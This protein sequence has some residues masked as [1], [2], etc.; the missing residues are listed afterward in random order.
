MRR[1]KYWTSGYNPGSIGG[2]FASSRKISLVMAFLLIFSGFWSGWRVETARAD[3]ADSILYVKMEGDDANGGTGWDDAF[4]TLQKAL[5][6]A[7]TSSGQTYQIWIAKGTYIPTHTFPASSVCVERRPDPP[8]PPES[9]LCLRY[10]MQ[11]D[12]RTAHFAMKNDVAIYGGFAG[13]EDPATFSLADRDFANNETILSGDLGNHLAAYHVFYHP[14]LALD[15][16]AVLD[17]VTISGGRGVEHQGYGGGMYNDRSSPAL[18]HVTFSGNYAQ[19]AGGAMANQS[20]NPTLTHV[21]ISGNEARRGGGMYNAGGSSPILTHVTISDNKAFINEGGG[22]SNNSGSS[23]VLTHV[24]ISGNEA[25]IGGG[26]YNSDSSPTL[27]N[28]I[29]SG[30]KARDISPGG[31]VGG[32]IYTRNGSLTLT[33]VTIS[34]NWAAFEAGGMYNDESATTIRNSIIWGNSTTDEYNPSIVISPWWS[35]F[36]VISHSL[37]EYSN[38][39][40][41]NWNASVGSD[42]GNNIDADP[43][44]VDYQL[45][46]IDSTSSGDYRLRKDSPAIN[47]GNSIDIPNG[48]ITDL[49]GNIRVAGAS[50][51]MGA[52]EYERVLPVPRNLIGTAGDRQVTLSWDVVNF[53]DSYEVYKYEGATGPV[54]TDDWELVARDINVTTYEVTEL[55]NGTGYAFAVKAVSTLGDSDF[56]DA[57]AIATSSTVPDAPSGVSATAGNGQAVVSFTVPTNNGGSAIT[58]YTVTALVNGSA[59]GMTETGT[60]SPITVSGLTNGTAYTFSVR[61]TSALGDSSESD[62]SGEVTP[63]TVPGAPTRVSATAGNGQAVVSFTAPTNNGGS[64]IT[65]YTVTALVDGSATGMTATGTASPITVTGL[66]NGTSYTF[67]VRATNAAGDSAESSPT[68]PR[69]PLSPAS[70]PDP[71]PAPVPDAPTESGNNSLVVLVISTNGSITIPVGGSGEVSLGE[72][73]SIVIPHGASER[74]QHIT[75]EKVLN[76]EDLIS[77]GEALASDIYELMK[78]FSEKFDKPATLTFVFDPSVAGSNQTFAIF[79][80]DETEKKWIKVGGEV[81]GNTIRAEVDQLTKF[82]VFAIDEEASATDRNVIVFSDIFEHWAEESIKQAVLDGI[83]TGYPDGTFRP[84]EPV[85]RAE[86]TVMLA[87]AL[88]LDGSGAVLPFTDR[89]E[90][91]AWAEEAVARAVLAGIVNGYGAGRFQ[92][93]APITRSEM[94]TMIARALQLPTEAITKTDFTDDDRIPGWAKSAVESLR[95]LDIVNGRGDGKYVPDDKL[96]RAE[97][98]VAL[99]RMLRSQGQD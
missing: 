37:I 46:T 82:A 3:G 64:A 60:A 18:T 74:E 61:A 6:T 53:A 15:A 72:E 67:T 48:I 24:T 29:I 73:I 13:T 11:V 81:S 97:S 62:P 17:G 51:D 23:P 21:T 80:Y 91:G 85:S 79:Y 5:D 19:Y 71:A 50:V 86:F 35:T 33:H 43:K 59:T 41:D 96:T 44:F 32:G 76:T 25:N 58:G 88:D 84:D 30:N 26:M 20:S 4:A 55:T 27:T 38:G 83:I 75:I 65:G 1:I 49:D 12:P 93:N 78:N 94:A 8:N 54:T 87:H 90:I 7:D 39:S 66:T 10:E 31:R 2:A 9:W 16:T 77:E 70:A 52:Y 89:A 69:T 92:P 36:P 68:E 42:D 45:A 28:V 57:A 99:L 47:A 56:T 14:N 63:R 98:V 95:K 22:M 40:G 34:G